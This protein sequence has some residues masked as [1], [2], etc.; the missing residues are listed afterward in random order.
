MGAAASCASAMNDHYVDIHCHIL[1]GIDDGPRDWDDALAMARLAVEDGTTTIVATPHQLGGWP[2]NCGDDIRRLT[3]E[4]N[5]R[6]QME[7]I[8]LTVLPGGEARYEPELLERMVRGDVLT[9]GDHRRHMLVELPH[10]MYLPLDSLLEEF[11]SRRISAILAHPERNQGIM[12]KPE[13]L[14]D[15]VDAGCLAQITAGSLCGT[16]G[17]ELQQFSEWMIREGLIHVVSSDAHGPKTRRPLIG[18]AFERIRELVDEETALDL[19]CRTPA[20]V[21]AGRT[22][23]TGRRCVRRRRTG[24]FSR[25]EAA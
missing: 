9:L 20:R 13:L 23:T 14:G 24:W 21:A 8:P 19:C 12:R 18:R 11:A 16:L 3:A 25:R 5:E 10:E 7:Q 6:L 15:V 17:K 2:Q 4:L 22:V 1:P